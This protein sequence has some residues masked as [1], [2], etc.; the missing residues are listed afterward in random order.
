MRNT[1]VTIIDSNI[2]ANTAP[3][4]GGIYFNNVISTIDDTTIQENTVTSTNG[5]GMALTAGNNSQTSIKNSEILNNVSTIGSPFS[6]AINISTGSASL[7]DTHVDHTTKSNGIALSS[8]TTTLTGCVIENNVYV[9]NNQGGG[10]GIYITRGNTIIFNNTIQNNRGQGIYLWLID[11]GTGASIQKNLI[12]GNKTGTGQNGAGANLRSSGQ[13][14]LFSDN[15]VE[16]NVAGY[17]GI[18]PGAYGGGLYLN[19]TSIT[20]R[21]NI[22]RRNTSNC[23]SC[24]GTFAGSGGGIYILDDILLENNIITDN[25]ADVNGG[26]IKIVGA[27]PIAYHTTL[28]GNSPEGIHAVEDSGGNPSSPQ[29]YNTILANH[30][31][32]IY[33]DGDPLSTVFLE[34]TL[35]WNNTTDIS[36]TGTVFESYSQDG[37]PAFMDPGNY[38]Y[39]ITGSSAALNGCHTGYLGF[40]VDHQPRPPA[41]ECD[42]G[43][44]QYWDP[45]ELWSLFLSLIVKS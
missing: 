31:T 16:D 9:S 15:I 10:G 43:A 29:F 37:D 26:G 1:L 21:N 6:G 23:D 8:A 3:S 39:H 38:D 22:I 20:L 45:G 13:P 14:I 11:P 32:A 40:D 4:G 19:D 33:V 28:S 7:Q 44:D 5:S 18:Y 42:L 35:W 17:Y 25:T 27:S 12:K 24:D 34:S 30:T 2:Q 41:P 36:G